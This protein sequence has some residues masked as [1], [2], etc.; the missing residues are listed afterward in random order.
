MERNGFA[1]IPSSGASM[2]PFIQH[3]NICRFTRFSAADVSP[4]DVL[5]FWTQQGRL[6]GHRLL[7]VISNSD[8][9][10]YICKGDTNVQPDEPVTEQNVIGRLE[11]VQK[12]WGRIR[13][14]GWLGKIWSKA[15]ISS[16]I[17]TWV[18][19]RYLRWRESQTDN[20][21]EGAY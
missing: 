5:L 12:P 11:V 10:L 13:A 19:R 7:S 21:H 3:G 20:T 17:P 2:F 8:E 15:T 16:S 6:I 1:E 18:L 9:T 14:R 4:G